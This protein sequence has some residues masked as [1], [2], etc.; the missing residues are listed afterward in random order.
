MSF[1]AGRLVEEG[2]AHLGLLE[3]AW[4][5]SPSGRRRWTAWMTRLT[6][7]HPALTA[8][9]LDHGQ[10]SDPYNISDMPEPRTADHRLALHIQAFVP[11]QPLLMPWRQG[12][13]HAQRLPTTSM[14]S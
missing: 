1:L 8:Q 11:A 13:R 10:P 6:A 4:H 12:I 9:S 3:S 7:Y 14:A 2:T 5:Q